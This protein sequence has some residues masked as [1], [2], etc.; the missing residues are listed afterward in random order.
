[1]ITSMNYRNL[2]IR[3]LSL[4]LF[5]SGALLPYLVQA[6]AL[7]EI[8]VTAQ[9]REQSLQEVPI[10]LEAY[11]G[12]ILNKQGFRT[13]ED[14]SNFS[15]SVEIDVRTQD[16][17]IA[18]RG[19]GTIGNNLGLEGAVPI[20][21]DGVHFSRTSMIMGAFLDLERVEV[22][23]GPQPIAFGQ[24]ATAGAFSLTTKKPTAQ[25]EGD[26]TAEYGNFERFSLEGGVGGPI[27]DTWG[28]R[29]A[30]QY[31]RTG[32]YITDVI[33]GD[34]FPSGEET[35]GRLTLAWTPMDN[36]TAMFKAG[37]AIRRNEA[38]GNSVCRTK[39][40]EEL[41]ERSY[42]IPGQTDFP[43]TALHFPRDCDTNGFGRRGIKEG[44]VPLASPVDGI[45]QED[46]RGGIV[47]MTTVSRTVMDDLDAHDDLNF[48]NYRLGVDY[49]FANGI[50]VNSITGYEDY[51]RSSAHDNSSSPVITNVQHR[52][53]VFDLFSQEIR[54]SS[55]RGGMIEWEAGAFYQEEDIDIGNLGHPKYQ[56]ITLRANT[57]RP[58][59]SQDSWQDTRWLSGFGS[60]T[61]N[62]MNDQASL[63]VG[64]RFTDINKH[65][66]IQGYF[67]TWIYDIDPDSVAV[68]IDP[69]N[70]NPT[71]D[72]VGDGLVWGIDH[73][74]N[75]VGVPDGEVFQRVDCQDRARL[76][77]G[78]GV[79]T[80]NGGN[81]SFGATSDLR[82]IIDCSDL[83]DPRVSNPNINHCGQFAGMAGYWSHAYNPG[84]TDRAG[85]LHNAIFDER[86][87]R[88]VPEAWD[89]ASPVA[90]SGPMWGFR[91][92]TG[93]NLVYDRVYNDTSLDPQV[94]L[95]YRPTDD[96]SLYAK[97]ARAFKGGG[98]DISTA[99]LPSDLDAFPL[100]P[101]KAQNWEVGAKGTLL[102]GRANFNMTAFQISI[103]DLQLATSVPQGLETQSSITTN[104]GKQRTR[105]FE[106]DSRLAATEQLTLGI[107]GAFMWGKMVS[108]P[109]AGC[110]DEEF[111][112]ADVGPCISE[113]E[114]DA[115]PEGFPEG[116]ID[117]T[118]A[119][120]PRTPRYKIIGDL[121]YWYPITDDLKYTFNARTSFFD[122]FI[123]EVEEFSETVKYPDRTV[124]NLSLGLADM[125]D[126][127][128][129][130]LWG[131]NLL[132]AGFKYFPDFDVLADGR[133]YK[134]V[135]QRH[136]FSYGLQFQY[137]FG[138]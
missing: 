125:D 46:S 116:T 58:A 59:R 17:D 67:H 16:Q 133:Q 56:T 84:R 68:P 136:W 103:K 102:D 92:Q 42:T 121:D 23:R 13:M 107:A 100:L 26:I 38:E 15:P 63:D 9:R 47:D 108:Y 1:M 19:M 97:W 34:K 32:G 2:F 76:V 77:G 7:E 14:L 87:I 78:I 91:L 70:G 99:S 49:E 41:T 113:A 27:S 123:Y 83:S 79:G 60:V 20:F 35:A 94:T 66:H 11:T 86:G 128:N 43:I 31:D 55:P 65:S 88:T 40:W 120:A 134:E 61:F 75:C 98:A 73:E 5:A 117:R 119:E 104:A 85:E 93:N 114:A 21:V 101:E 96:I 8:V 10:S 12:D 82:S 6:Q 30:G 39:G 137:F 122:G 22:L 90:L 50:S 126:R 109:G 105:G 33:T 74:H 4:F 131:R 25:W 110:T 36:L 135:S 106:F 57:R 72:V 48:Y 53:E 69:R 127:W 28:I 115:N 130:S 64:A 71:G 52:G 54:F 80:A 37:I 118:G 138:R 129:V 95:R 124:I 45:N 111:E 29:I 51:Q 24:N 3:S 18:V 44:S 81:T 89:T 112:N 132:D 62:F